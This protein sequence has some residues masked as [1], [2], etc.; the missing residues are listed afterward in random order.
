MKRS[1]LPIIICLLMTGCALEI[2]TTP[3]DPS[4]TY[5]PPTSTPPAAPATVPSVP[6]ALPADPALYQGWQTYTNP[7]YGFSL[8]LP[9][10]WSAEEAPSSDLL[11]YGHLLDLHP[12]SGAEN[13]RMTFRRQGEDTPLW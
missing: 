13:I 8:R 6:T 1:F 4:S 9:E 7:Q 10:D 2:P 11:L 5:P 12:A 3:A